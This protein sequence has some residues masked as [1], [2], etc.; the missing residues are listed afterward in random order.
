MS[1]GS[2]RHSWLQLDPCTNIGGGKLLFLSFLARFFFFIGGAGDG[3]RT[4]YFSLANST[5]RTTRQ[6]L[7]WFHFFLLLLIPSERMYGCI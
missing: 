3:K 7:T 5:P 6:D 1:W 4:L 2:W